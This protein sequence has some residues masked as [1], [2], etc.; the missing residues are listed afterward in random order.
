[1]SPPINIDGS[2]VSSVTIDG[3]SVSE[4]TVDGEAVFSAI[5]DSGVLKYE[6]EDDLTDSFNS[7]NGTE[8]GTVT[9]T[10]SAKIGNQAAEFDAGDAVDTGIQSLTPPF[11]IGGYVSIANLNDDRAIFGNENGQSDDFQLNYSDGSGAYQVVQGT[12]TNTFTVSQATGSYAHIVLVHTDTDLILYQDGGDSE[13]GD[14]DTL[15][16]NSNNT[17]DNGTNFQFGSSPSGFNF[18]GRQD[19]NRIYSK[20]LSSTEVASWFNTGSI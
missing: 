14:E 5:P 4:V 17:I 1:M 16:A 15:S 20:A 3:T 12:N 18:I 9:F 7:N 19:D 2:S 13:G 6:Y 8:E 11:S 10:S